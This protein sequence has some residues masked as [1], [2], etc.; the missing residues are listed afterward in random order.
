MG[1]EYQPDPTGLGGGQALHA[2]QECGV[3][4]LNQKKIIS[5]PWYYSFLVLQLLFWPCYFVYEYPGNL[6]IV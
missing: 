6:W 2:A 5:N 3:R 1:C 4:K